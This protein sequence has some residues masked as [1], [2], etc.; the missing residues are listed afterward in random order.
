MSL[1]DFSSRLVPVGRAKYGVTVLFGTLIF[2]TILRGLAISISA[3]NPAGLNYLF[4]L[5]LFLSNP[6]GRFSRAIPLF[7]LLAVAYLVFLGVMTLKRLSDLETNEWFALFLLVPVLNILFFLLLC[8]QPAERVENAKSEGSKFFATLLPTS[9]LGSAIAGAIS[10]GLIA[11]LLGY[12]AVIGLGSY[13][14]T[15]FLAIPIFIG[16]FAAWIHAYRR[17]RSAAECSVVSAASIL[18]AAALIVGIAFEGIF[19]VLMALP[20]AVP[21]GI[22]GGFFA[23]V[24]QRSK[25]LQPRPATMMSLLMVLPLLFGAE[26][27]RPAYLPQHVVHSSVE[28]AAPPEAVWEK[29]LD[30]PPIEEKPHGVLRLGMAYPIETRTIGSGLQ[31]RR[32]TNFST[33]ISREPLLAWEENKHLAFQVADEPPL[34]K[35]TSPYGAI[36]VRHLEDHDFR[37]GRVDFFLTPLANGGTRLDCWSSYEN[38]MWPGE[39]WQLWTDEI[40]R[41]IQLRVFRQ[42][43]RLAEA[44][45]QTTA[46]R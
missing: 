2:N 27:W 12:I 26:S 39:Y 33:G 37:P 31:A 32:E 30:L 20:L 46:V 22:L 38:R 40:V 41:Q 10:G 42:V 9:T 43:K 23:Y 36:Q 35:E 45:T 6:S 7:S 1:S 21:M 29:I 15:L 18:L 13:G 4:P 16:Y 11:T 25:L 3:S 44:S 19:C 8:L 5:G 14:S 28:I 34:M 17:P 24:S